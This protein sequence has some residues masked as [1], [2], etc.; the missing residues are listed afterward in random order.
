MSKDSS[1]DMNTWIDLIEWSLSEDDFLQHFTI[2]ES[3]LS[4]FQE[5]IPNFPFNLLAYISTY[6]T[7]VSSKTLVSS[8]TDL[9]ICPWPRVQLKLLLSIIILC[10]VCVPD[11]SVW[12]SDSQQPFVEHEAMSPDVLYMKETHPLVIPCRV[13]HPNVTATLSKVSATQRA[14]RHSHAFEFTFGC[15]GRK[16][17]HALVPPFVLLHHI[18]HILRTSSLVLLFF[19]PSEVTHASTHFSLSR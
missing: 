13:T 2:S 19:S 10:A 15:R 6:F 16:R 3:F 8:E 11:R 4:R 9:Q 7:S 14:G 5:N 1:S 18:Q 17:V 12:V